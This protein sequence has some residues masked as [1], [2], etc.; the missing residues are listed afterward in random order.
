MIGC[1]AYIPF[2]PVLAKPVGQLDTV[3]TLVSILW[4]IVLYLLKM[5][6]STVSHE[7]SKRP[8]FELELDQ[9]I[10]NLDSKLDSCDTQY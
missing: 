4:E 9:R 3:V 6:L 8:C 5:V 1:W 7:S 2:H 10:Q